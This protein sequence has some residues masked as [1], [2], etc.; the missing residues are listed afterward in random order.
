VHGIDDKTHQENTIL[1]TSEDY[2]QTLFQAGEPFLYDDSYVKLRELRVGLDLPPSI[3]NLF[4][5]TNV[6]LAFV[7]RNLWTHTK[8]PN[9]DPEFTYG[10]GNYQG[11]EFAALPTTR[12]LGLN[13]RIT[14]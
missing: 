14:P 4:R 1:R 10:T 11:A 2:F 5:A 9:V 3:T 8:V 13:L 6:N 12:S 7:G